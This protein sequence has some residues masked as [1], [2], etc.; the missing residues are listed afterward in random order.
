[1]TVREYVRQ[2]PTQ[3]LGVYRDRATAEAVLAEIRRRVAGDGR[4]GAAQDYLAALN[5]E[6]R[7]E[8]DESLLG[9]Q[10]GF[11]V[12]KE[13]TKSLAVALPAAIA[14]GAVIGALCGL[15]PFGGLGLVARVLVGAAIGAVG[16]ATV[17]FIVGGGLGV[18]GPE[19]AEAAERGVTVRAW[20][21]RPE[22]RDVMVNRA[23]IRLD[24]L[25]RAGRAIETITTEEQQTD[26]GAVQRVER[27]LTQPPGGDWGR[28]DAGDP[29]HGRAVEGQ[30]FVTDIPPNE[31]S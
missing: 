6:T 31:D 1:M 2:E 20:P 27:R 30:D 15:I 10:A 24:V 14:V 4:I 28:V 21:D 11:I 12:T 7:Q 19:E 3:L 8:I 16:G 13:Q 5:A 29:R 26:D 17:G 22:V 23:P 18:R 9:A 25:D